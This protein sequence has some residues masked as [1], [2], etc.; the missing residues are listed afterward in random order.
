MNIKKLFV[1]L[2]TAIVVA[3]VCVFV[4]CEVGLGPAV[5][6]RPPSIVIEKPEVDKVIRNKFVISGTWEDDGTIDSVYVM[7]KRTDGK[8]LDGTSLER[9]VEAT[10]TVDEEDDEKGTW[11]AIVD[12]LEKDNQIIDGS[13]QATVYIQDKGNH[14]TSQITTFTIDNTAPVLILSKPNSTPEDQTLSAYGQRLFLEG[15]IA[16]STK[17]TWIQLDFYSGE[18]CT[19]AQYLTTIETEMISPTDVNSNNARLAIYNTDLTQKYATEYYKLYGKTEKSGAEQVYAKITVYDTAETFPVEGENDN[20]TPS[21]KIKGNASQSFYLTKKLAESITKS[22]TANGY[23]LAPIDIY[24][25]LN[26]TYVLKN[27]SRAA[28]AQSIKDELLSDEQKKSISVFTINPENSPYFTISGLKTLNLDGKDFEEGN[29]IVNG[30]QTLEVSVFMGSDSIALK[31]DENFYVYL[32][33]CDKY[34]KPVKEDVEENRIK[35]YSKYKETGSGAEKKIYYKVGGKTDHKTSSGAYV[36][37]IPMNKS[38]RADPDAGLD[39]FVSINLEYGKNY[40]IRVSGKDTEGNDIETTDNGYGFCFTA[41]GTAPR[42]T[43]TE[44][45]DNTVFIKKGDGLH[46]KGSVTS[47]GGEPRFTISN[48]ANMVDLPLTPTD[49]G[50]WTFEKQIAPEE[51]GFSQDDSVI[52]SLI[53]SA[54]RDATESTQTKSVWYD[55]EGPAIT[56]SDPVPLVKANTVKA[57]GSTVE[58]DSINGKVT[59]SGSIIDEFDSRFGSASWKVEQNGAQVTGPG[60]SGSLEKNFTFQLDTTKLADNK[61]AVVVISAYDFVGNL[62]ETRYTCWVDQSTDVPCIK[63]SESGKD[64]TK[65]VGAEGLDYVKGGHNLF[66][67]SGNLVLSVSDDDDIEKTTVKV[68]KYDEET[69]SLADPAQNQE[70][71]YTST[72]VITHTL[73]SEVAIYQVEVKAYDTSTPQNVNTTNFFIRVT[74]TGP[75]VTISSDKDYV[76]TGGTYILTLSIVDEGNKPYTIKTNDDDA[77]AETVNADSKIISLTPTTADP[78]KFTVIDKNASFTEKFFNPKFDDEIPSVTISNCPTTMNETEST[79]FLFKGT[80]SDDAG[81]GKAKSGIKK[82]EIMF[83]DKADSTIKTEWLECNGSE[84]WNYEATWASTALADVFANETEKTV[85]V[86]ATD[87][88]GNEITTSQDFTYDKM[89]PTVTIGTA[90]EAVDGKSDLQVPITITDTNPVKPKVTV[91]NEAGSPIDISGIIVSELSGSGSAYT[92]TITL[93]FKT[94]ITDGTYIF[95]VIGHDQNGRISQPKQIK[96]KRDA[97]APTVTI[98]NPSTDIEWDQA[99]TDKTYTFKVKSTDGQGTGTAKLYYAFKDTNSTPADD[100]WTI[101]TA[102]DGD[103]FIPNTFSEEG[104]YYFFVKAEDKS[105][106]VS[107]VQSRKIS[108]DTGAPTLTVANPLDSSRTN[109]LSG[110][111]TDSGYTISGTLTDTNKLSATEALVI[112]VGGVTKKTMTAEAFASS[113]SWSYIISRGTDAGTIINDTSVEVEIIAKDI[114]GKSN[115]TVTKKYNLYYDTKEPELTVSAPA[116]DEP[117]ETAYKAIKGTVNDDGYGI[118]KIEY[119]LYSGTITSGSGTVVKTSDNKDVTSTNFPVEIKGEQWYIKRT[120]TTDTNLINTIP[121]GTSEG[122][123]TLKVTASEKKNAAG[124]QGGR[125]TTVY[126][127]FYY[128]RFNPTLTETEVNTKGATTNAGFE[129]KGKVWDTNGLDHIEIS[130]GTTIW[131]SENPAPTGKTYTDAISLTK[132]I[133]DPGEGQTNWSANFKVGSETTAYPKINDGTQDFT[134]TAYDITG[135]TKQLSRT[136]IVDTQKPIVDNVSITSSTTGQTIGGVLWYTTTSIPVEVAVTEKGLSGIS[137]VEYQVGTGA[138]T[139]LSFTNNKYQGTISF[140]SDGAQSFKVKATDVAG[141]VSDENTTNVNIDTTAPNLTAKYYKVGTGTAKAVENI[142]Y[143]KTSTQI[144]VYGNYDDAQSGIN[145]LTFDYGSPTVTYSTTAIGDVAPTDANYS[146][147][148]NAIAGYETTIKSWKAV[149]TPSESGAFTVSGSN[150]TNNP[151]GSLKVFDVTVDGEAPVVDNVKLIEVKDSGEKQAYSDGSKYFVNNTTT[152]KTFKVSGVATDNVGVDSV[153]LLITK[154]DTSTTKTATRKGSLGQWYFDGIDLSDWNGTG[155]SVKI[156][157]K[158]KAGNEAD[159][160]VEFDIAFDVTAPSTI[161]KIDDSQKN[162]EFRIGDAAND[163]GEPDVGGKYSNGSYGSALTMQLRGNFPDNEGGSGIN[164]FY[165]KTFNNQEVT[166]DASK[167]SGLSENGKIYFKSLEDLKNHVIANKTDIFSPITVEAKN[168]EYNITPGGSPATAQNTIGRFGGEPVNGYNVNPKGY[169]Q[170]RTSVETNFKATIKGFQ[171]GKNFLV[172]VAEDNVGNTAVDYAEVA[173]VIYPSYSLNVDI[174]SPAIPTKQEGTVFTNLQETNGVV[175]SGT[176]SD[177]PNVANGSSGLSKIILTCDGGSGSVVVTSF[178]EPTAEERMAATAVNDAYSSDATLKHWEA[179]VSSLLPL[180]GMA[181]ISAKVI[182]NAGFETSVPV[183]NI[184]IDTTAPMVTISSPATGASV[185]KTFTISGTAN[186]GSGAGLSSDNLILYYTKTEPE[187]ENGVY[188]KPVTASGWTQLSTIPIGTDWKQENLDVSSI[189][190][191]GENTVV[192]FTIAAKDSS[193]TGNTGYATPVKYTVDRKKPVFD[194]SNSTIQTTKIS[195]VS[196]AWFNSTTLNIKGKYSDDGGSGAKTIKYQVKAGNSAVQ[197]EQSIP[198]SNGSFDINVSGFENGSN[199]LWLWAIDDVG[200]ASE[201]GSGYTVRIDSQAPSFEPLTAADGEDY[202]EYAFSKVKLTNGKNPKTLKFYVVEND[203]G[204]EAGEENNNFSAFNITVGNTTITPDTGSS[205]SS[206][207]ENGKYLITVVIGTTD[208]ANVDGYQTVLVT[209]N[210][211]AGNVSM[212]QAIGIL[213]KDGDPPVPSFTSPDDSSVV[214]KTITVSGKVTDANE[215][216]QIILT[217][218]CGT[219]IKTY[220]YIKGASSGNTITYANS[221]WSVEI[222]TTQLDNTFTTDGK[223]LT[224]SLKAT[225]EAGNETESAVTRTLKINQNTDRPVITIGSGVD[226]TKKNNNE[227]WVKGSSTIYGSVNDDDGISTFKVYKKGSKDSDFSD[228]NA[229][230]SGGSWNVK[231]PKD[232]SYTLRFEVKDRPSVGTATTFTSAAITSTSTDAAILATPIIEDSPEAT[233]QN[234]NPTSNKFGD[235]KEN[236]NTLIPICLDTTNPSLIINAISLDNSTWYEDVNKSD[237][238][239]GGDNDTLY[240]KVTASDSSGLYGTTDTSGIT[241]EFTGTMTLGEDEY[242]LQCPDN[243]C[244]VAKGSGDNEFIITVTNFGTAKKEATE[245]PFSGTMTLTVTAKDKAEMETQKSLSRTVDNAAPVLKIS[246]PDSVSSTAVVSGTVE[247]EVVNPKIYF[248]VT[249]AA[250]TGQLPSSLQ[251]AKDSNLWKQDKFASLAYNIYFDGT[252]SDTTT[253]TDLFRQ[254]LVT[255]GCT[256]SD[257][258]NNNTYIDLTP[259]YVWI[260]AE[261]VCGNISYDYATVVVDPQGNRPNV[262][263]SYPNENGVKLGGTI[264]LMGT[265]N[266]NVEAKYVWIKI[267]TNNDGQWKLADYNTLKAATNSGYTFGQISTNKKIGTGEGEVNITPSESNISDIAIMAKVTGGSWNQNINADGE[268]IPSGQKNNTVK[269]WVSATDDDNGNGTSILESSPVARTF[270]VDKDNPYFV[271]DSLKLITDSGSEQAY[272]EGMSV[273]GEWWLVG[274]INDDVPG[275]RTISIKEG[276]SDTDTPYITTSGQEI[277]T[278]NYQFTKVANGS[279]WN[280]NFKIKVGATTGTGERSF[281]ITATEDKDSNALQ[282]YKD[283]II[284]YDNLP[285]TVAAHTSESFKIESTVKNSQGYYSLSSAAYEANDGDTGVDRIAVYFTKTV[286]GTTYVFDPMYKRTNAASKLATV[287]TGNGIKQD[288]A[289]G[290]DMLYWGSATVSAISNSTLTLSAAAPSYVHVGGLA[291]IKGVI[292]R[293]ASVSGTT[294]V[295]SGEPGTSETV[296]FAVANVVDNTTAE[297]KKD[298]A[299]A[300]KTDYGYGYCNDYIYDDG[301]MILENLHKDDSKSWTWELYV[302]SKNIPDGDVDIHYVVFDKAGNCMHDVVEGASVENNKPRLVSVALGVDINQDGNITQGDN[303]ITNYYP[304][305]LTEKPGVYT[306]AST[307]INISGITVK[308]KMS[309]TP[310]IVGGNG[311]LFYQWKTK[312]T[313]DWQKVQGSGNELMSGNNDYDDA[314]FN[315]ANDYIASGA[316]ALTT[317]TGTITHDI[318]WLI[319]NSTDNDTDFNINYEIFD[320][321]DGK[322]VFTDSNKV[323]I[324]ITGIN[325]QVRDKVAP[326]VTIDDFYWNSLTDNS[327]YTSKAANQ[328]KS[329]ADLEGHIELHGDLPTDTFNDTAGASNAEFDTD[330]KVSGKIKITGTAS[331]NRVL[332]ALYLSIP[333]MTSSSETALADV[334]LDSIEVD[335]VRFYKVATYDKTNKKWKNAAGNADFTAVGSL[336]TNGFEF[337]V[338]TDTNTFDLDDGHSVDW[339]ILWDSAKLSNVVQT[340]VGI[341]VLAYDDAENA[342]ADANRSGIDTRTVDVVPYITDIS[343]GDMDSG[344]KKFLR[345][346]ASGAFVARKGDTTN[347]NVTISGYNLNGSTVYLGGSS[348]TTTSGNTLVVAKTNL[349]KSGSID[350][351]KTVGGV[352]IKS[353]NNLNDD[354]REYNKEASQYAPNHTDGRYIYMWDTTTTA[355]SGTEAVMKPVIGTDGKKTGNMMWYYAKNNQYL[356]AGGTELCDSWGGAIVGGNFAYN[357]K[358]V[359]S[360]VYLHN[361]SWT[362]GTGGKYQYYGSAQW[363]KTWKDYGYAWNWNVSKNGGL[364]LGNL[365]F[366]GDNNYT[367]NDTVMNRYTNMKMEVVGDAADTLNMVAY[368]DNSENTRSIVFWRFHEGTTYNQTTRKNSLT[369]DTYTDMTK[370]ATNTGNYSSGNGGNTK[371]GMKTPK[372][373][374]EITTVK[375]GADSN[376]F[377]MIYDSVKDVV[378]IAYYDEVGGGLKIKYLNNP[379]AGYYQHWSNSWSNDVEI[380]MDAAGQYVSMKTDGSG[381]IHLAYYDSTGSYLKYA[382]VTPT[383]NK[384]EITSLTVSK[385]VLVDTLFTNGMY[386]SITLR[387]FATDDVRPVITSYSISYGGT[388]YSLRTSWPLTSVENIE[389]GAT[390]DDGYTG[391]WETVAVVSANA[392]KQDNTYTETNSTGYTGNIVVGYTASK[393]EQAELLF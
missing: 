127:P 338:L 99:L 38:L 291:K 359:P 121:L 159:E 189:A 137:K 157:V 13:Y 32:L 155:A 83:S 210:D 194:T 306:N 91:K 379:A 162:L 123:L 376:Y 344:T 343:T 226:F 140:A 114:T 209:V 345:R 360:W 354:A 366:E 178:T 139:P 69:E 243:A 53:F 255:T 283:F 357:S 118:D 79:S 261:D 217:A 24:N 233:E 207:N 144:T 35:L 63:N 337:T 230:Y 329:V 34:G 195:E 277:T 174:T 390:A 95:E 239:L 280:Y 254:Y 87:G 229:S 302:N 321:T 330:D 72:S 375:S 107:G 47:E 153:E 12:P 203:S 73:P 84:N 160:N 177:K 77:T 166:I 224:L 112:K 237:L 227:I 362:I 284:R 384:S 382:L 82:V 238:Y 223:D 110:E 50:T 322:T 158:D 263:V 258:I 346:S 37:S 22:Q 76:K 117:V 54:T 256:T 373:R 49:E 241:A 200:N 242:E 315:N 341:K 98:E 151:T 115:N 326:T 304:E 264:R 381:N 124:T 134:I 236:G 39:G 327:V 275:I 8:L 318:A 294:V 125:S 161:H 391:K 307:A 111:V 152:G 71:T 97:G 67:K 120:D 18:E 17:E 320:S 133:S 340:N 285:P 234:P 311:D 4:S 193:G 219:T 143:V 267:D 289:T 164:K 46:V 257:A 109:V 198:T 356:Y 113:S 365:C 383:G 249:K 15:S 324:N 190:D 93:P 240:I 80:A 116:D 74:G 228:A 372:N 182:D 165:Y 19:D 25:V 43:I 64:I 288:S 205:I 29:T 218:T 142:I 20:I 251:P 131:T 163:L 85:T 367:Y 122:A 172:I 333:D 119:V 55:V 149:F 269:M 334:T 75:D 9:K 299:V 169:V 208:L 265:A 94:G 184:T 309:V 92:S 296:E 268:L 187:K 312:K 355:Y 36:F 214:N 108:I 325:L 389:A 186:D 100:E 78:V 102:S 371:N 176:V 374:E 23:G 201:K 292:Y 246:A 281:R 68:Q 364:G 128:D 150:R 221:I 146:I 231:L 90:P 339:Q 211:S 199:T 66:V 297:S 45:A 222:D 352:D 81:A 138:W 349:T 378:Y 188:K 213:N 348:I 370:E 313:T 380:D 96:I 104:E 331:D 347:A 101:E 270:I 278:G 89:A 183:A 86:K 335:G 235:T 167:T 369:N 377:D 332:T 1:S 305:G 293:I 181:I 56:L 52:Y 6:T 232:D 31:D 266:D 51:L 368:F 191:D 33:E 10:F 300:L 59:F 40:I 216:T 290:G 303:E 61:E 58:K 316:T 386:N 148:A 147:A 103:K 14:T 387:Q 132:L 314:D 392:P 175:I 247:G 126:V 196:T 5:D 202:Q 57:D 62:S 136:V 252:T 168:V 358:G 192:Y 225:D 179:D 250:A 351:Q 273:K 2:F 27:E 248:A 301:D 11:Q 323:S 88:A 271:Q 156:T 42:I 393:L 353:L 253:H 106:N 16:D 274:T 308:G 363:G 44:P 28:D 272:K 48:E 173:G 245:K 287:T 204:I 170:F 171:E 388:K 361:T 262:V 342:G 105:G 328:I 70:M 286:S 60:L 130:D 212:P 336:G 259:V 317:Q 7:L 197:P 220:Q 41:G 135:K 65:G 141:N 310:E 276:G 154:N 350:V 319:E 206:P 295:L 129:F 279:Y 260:K 26:G 3:S 180:S 185:G 145:G 298:G 21:G 385:K 30:T 215:V 282:S 244:T